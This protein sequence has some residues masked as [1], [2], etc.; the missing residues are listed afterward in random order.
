MLIEMRRGQ[1]DKSQ[2]TKIKYQMKMNI[3][4]YLVIKE[5]QIETD[6]FFAY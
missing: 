4:L 3:Q 1:M 5:M 2:K 6:H